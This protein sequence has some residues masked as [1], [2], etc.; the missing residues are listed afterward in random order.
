MDRTPGVPVVV[1]R[2]T[3]EAMVKAFK[4]LNFTDGWIKET[5]LVF[6]KSIKQAAEKY[7]DRLYIANTTRWFDEPDEVMKGVY[8]FLG[9]EWNS[10][11]LTMEAYNSKS[12]PASVQ[13]KPFKKELKN[14]NKISELIDIN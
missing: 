2:K 3:H 12:L 7:P 1:T 5:L 13:A 10:D 4:K 14:S 9:L 6:D 11:Y 8:D